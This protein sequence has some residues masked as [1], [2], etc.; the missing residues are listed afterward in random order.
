MRDGNGVYSKPAGIDASPDTTIESADWN[1][2][3]ADVEQ[4]L[5]TPRPI[6]AGG[7]GAAT[8]VG[9][10]DALS[11]QGANI[12]SAT[13]TNLALATGVAVTV[14]GTTTITA[15]GT[16]AAG[17][18]RLLTFA[19]ALTLTHNAASLILPG[20]ANITTAAGDTA[21]LLSLGSGNWRALRYTKADGTPIVPISDISG[22][23]ASSVHAAASKATPV[24][25]DEIAL[26]DSAASN[27]LKKLTWA[28]IKATLKTYFDTLYYSSGSDIAVADGGTGRSSHTAYA[29][30][31]GG[32]TTT[33]AQQSIASVGSSGQV[34]TSNGAAALPTF[35]SIDISGTLAG[36]SAGDVGSMAFLAPVN[37]TAATYNPGATLAGSALNYAGIQVSGGAATRGTTLSGTWRCMG[38]SARGS[39]DSATYASLWLRIS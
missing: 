10:A 20:G 4:D 35:Q 22:N 14:T 29:V 23:I 11:T 31:C 1:S 3:T 9:G 19:G 12:A 32:T 16:V 36:Q 13:T 34:L 37:S 24:D 17:V 2:F 8:A 25:A 21:E 33:T 6:I 7:T 18:R 38:Q 27:G 28:N 15:F 30:L 39:V 5:N 26:V